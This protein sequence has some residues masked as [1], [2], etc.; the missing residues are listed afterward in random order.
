MFFDIAI[1]V[2]DVTISNAVVFV[3]NIAFENLIVCIKFS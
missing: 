3:E 1:K 2:N